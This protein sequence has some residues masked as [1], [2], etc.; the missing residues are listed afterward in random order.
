[1][2]PM[3]FFITNET[4]K[5]PDVNEVKGIKSSETYSKRGLSRRTQYAI[6]SCST[7]REES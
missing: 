2:I 3:R 1:M 5:R 6:D 4:M 7:F